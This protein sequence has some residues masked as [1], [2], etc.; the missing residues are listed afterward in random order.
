MILNIYSNRYAII[1]KGLGGE[2]LGVV[3]SDIL[4]WIIMNYDRNFII[5]AISL[6]KATFHVKNRQTCDHLVEASIKT[7]K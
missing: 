7:I 3:K 4:N 5:C 6:A 2:V 1:N